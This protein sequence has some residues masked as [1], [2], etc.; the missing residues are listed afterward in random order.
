MPNKFVIKSHDFAKAHIT[1]SFPETKRNESLVLE[2]L[3]PGCP[4]HLIHESQ[5]TK[6]IPKSIGNLSII[7]Q[8]APNPTYREPLLNILAGLQL[9]NQPTTQTN[10]HSPNNINFIIQG[11]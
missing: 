2:E 11:N 9:N 3:K 7:T 6:T 5:L 8:G 1:N 4:H 10:G